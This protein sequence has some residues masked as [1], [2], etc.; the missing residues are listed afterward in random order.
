MGDKTMGDK[1][2]GGASRGD[3]VQDE[4]YIAKSTWMCGAIVHGWHNGQKNRDRLRR[5]LLQCLAQLPC[6]GMLV[7]RSL[8]DALLSSGYQIASVVANLSQHTRRSKHQKPICV[9]D[10]SVAYLTRPNAVCQ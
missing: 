5:S 1:T 9:S 3:Y 8:Q 4:R 10:K 6:P 2:V 7:T